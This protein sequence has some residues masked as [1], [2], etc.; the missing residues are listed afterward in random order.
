MLWDLWQDGAHCQRKHGRVN[1]LIMSTGRKEIKERREERLALGFHNLYWGCES[2][3]SQWWRLLTTHLLQSPRSPNRAGVRSLT[4]KP[5]GALQVQVITE[6]DS[7]ELLLVNT[8]AASYCSVTSFYVG[9]KRGRS[10]NKCF[11]SNK[12]KKKAVVTSLR[13]TSIT[14][15][16]V[17]KLKRDS[18]QASKAWF[19]IKYRLK[20]LF[21][22]AII[23][24]SN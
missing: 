8:E 12:L 4:Q 1:A 2:M 5:L 13:N 21:S 23:G 10:I 3:V 24:W 9:Q 17:L 6:G 7:S 11:A 20:I 19:F 14:L 18:L 16:V 15:M 22:K